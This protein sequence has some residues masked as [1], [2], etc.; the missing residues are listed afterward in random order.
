[1]R[2]AA[3]LLLPALALT[4]LRKFNGDLFIA[5]PDEGTVCCTGHAVVVKAI[6]AIPETLM[7]GCLQTQNESTAEQA[8]QPQGKLMPN[9]LYHCAHAK[10][11]HTFGI[12]LACSL[13]QDSMRV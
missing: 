2:S 10:A 1:M 6:T 7:D 8:L 11:A 3:L 13:L 9:M 4:R 5:Q 12:A